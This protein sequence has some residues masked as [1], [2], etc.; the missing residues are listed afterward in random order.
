MNK[1]FK[2][3]SPSL[4]AKLLASST[5]DLID[6]LCNPEDWQEEVIEFARHEIQ[7]RGVP[8]AEIESRKRAL[9]ANELQRKIFSNKRS[10][11]VTAASIIAAII[12]I[13]DL[14]FLIYVWFFSG[15][16]EMLGGWEGIKVNPLILI[17]VFILFSCAVGMWYQKIFFAR[18]L[19]FYQLFQIVFLLYNYDKIIQFSLLFSLVVFSLYVT[20]LN[21]LNKRQKRMRE[22]FRL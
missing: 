20:A 12:S 2:V 13:K 8:T 6:I 1:T 7:R 22:D 3:I 10:R 19:V 9:Q 21:C 15:L 18:F 4:S 14:V 11:W 16:P 5:P 17:D